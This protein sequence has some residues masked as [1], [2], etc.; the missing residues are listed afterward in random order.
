M[1]TSTL[2]ILLSVIGIGVALAS[3][4]WSRR[5]AAD[6]LAG[7]AAASGYQLLQFAPRYLRT[8]PYFWR[9]GRGQLIFYVTVADRSGGRRAGYVRLGGWLMGLLSDQVDVIWDG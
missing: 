4:A 1:R 3:C 5:R 2:I 8:G 7:W 9:H 6:M